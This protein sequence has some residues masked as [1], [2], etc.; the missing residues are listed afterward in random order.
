[1]EITQGIVF[2]SWKR[3]KCG[4]DWKTTSAP[5]GMV[6]AREGEMEV[7]EGYPLLPS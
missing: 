1:M 5:V 6:A 2:P 7:L 3:W 4:S